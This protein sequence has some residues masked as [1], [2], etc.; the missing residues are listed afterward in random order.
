MIF[1][2]ESKSKIC[3]WEGGRGGGRLNKWIFLLRIQIENKK[4]KL[5]WRGETGV[6]NFFTMN[7]SL[8]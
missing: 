1:R 2:K 4:R 6:S 8:K 3:F 7:P 5:G